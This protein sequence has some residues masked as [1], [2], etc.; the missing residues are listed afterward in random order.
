MNSNNQVYMFLTFI[1]VYVLLLIIILSL[2][3]I[4]NNPVIKKTIITYLIFTIIL[5]WYILR[6]KISLTIKKA[7][8]AIYSYLKCSARTAKISG[9]F[10]IIV[11][12][13]LCWIYF[14]WTYDYLSW[15]SKAVLILY[16]ESWKN[17]SIYWHIWLGLV[18][19]CYLSLILYRLSVIAKR[20]WQHYRNKRNNTKKNTLLFNYAIKDLLYSY[21]FLFWSVFLVTYY[22]HY[23]SNFSNW[24]LGN[25]GVTP[26]HIVPEW[27]FLPLYGVLKSIP[28][29]LVGI[30]SLVILLVVL[31]LLPFLNKK[32]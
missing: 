12:S 24:V 16:W 30:L 5:F 8:K 27:Y 23:F 26:K 11:N 9:T 6:N 3:L 22:P 17:A 29:K 2:V 19:T 15:S 10:Q 21:I 25:P 14:L 18:V 1:C 4:L 32:K 13:I 20:C 31:L 28:S 7:P